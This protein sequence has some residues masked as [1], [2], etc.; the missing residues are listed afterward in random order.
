MG[1]PLRHPRRNR[2][3]Y[4]EKRKNLPQIA[5]MFHEKEEHPGK[6]L[7]LSFELESLKIKNYI[8]KM[9]DLKTRGQMSSHFSLLIGTEKDLSVSELLAVRDIL[10]LEL[11]REQNSKDRKT[12]TDK[13]LIHDIILHLLRQWI[14]GNAHAQFK[15]PVIIQY[16]TIKRKL[17][18]L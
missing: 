8:H 9:S 1:V 18:G 15:P 14:K 10:K 16:R 11:L 12:Y 2:L 13:K 5:L 17:M 3:L 7:S 4:Y 6:L